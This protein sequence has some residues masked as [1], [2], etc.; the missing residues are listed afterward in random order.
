MSNQPTN[1]FSGS[2]FNA[3][4]NFA[5]NY[6]DQSVT[7]IDTQN[8][9]ASDPTSQQALADLKQLI[10]SIQQNNPNVTTEAQATNIIDV[11][12][13]SIEKKQPGKLA[14]LCKQILNPERHLKATK[15]TL[16]EVA[17][18]Y[19]EESVIAKAAITYLDT[20]SADPE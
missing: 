6:G 13:G 5:S 2:N 7:R 9:Y 20:M 14:S 10:N 1:D 17:K 19:L 3:P 11:E 16:A 15:A 4:V 18:H 12:F 8:N